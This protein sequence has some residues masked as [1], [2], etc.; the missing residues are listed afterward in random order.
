[1]YEHVK[2]SYQERGVSEDE[3]KERAARTVYEAPRGARP[4][5]RRVAPWSGT[6]ERPHPRTRCGPSQSASTGCALLLGEYVKLRDRPA[7]DRQMLAAA[8]RR[9]ARS[10]DAVRLRTERLGRA[11]LTADRPGATRHLEPSSRLSSRGH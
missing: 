3:A 8:P 2:E 10:M 4:R 5:P 7:N 6:P 11:A 1:M 9:A